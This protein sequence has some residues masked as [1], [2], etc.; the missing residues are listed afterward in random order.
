MQPRKQPE[1]RQDN[2]IA[3][4]PR[5]VPESAPEAAPA[6]PKGLLKATR[7]DW[8][9][10][11]AQPVASLYSEADIPA[12]RR[13]FLLRDE[14]ERTARE[15]RKDGATA[16]GSKGQP[17]AHPLLARVAGIDAEVRQLE[18]LFGLAPAARARLGLA[19][20]EAEKSRLE[21][22]HRRLDGLE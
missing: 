1:R 15:I 7:D 13:L 6:P 8:R 9:T 20:G 5:P 11:W 19:I 3:R 14:R 12:L 2:R 22:L 4:L 18:V 17:V 16:D 21:I 10:L